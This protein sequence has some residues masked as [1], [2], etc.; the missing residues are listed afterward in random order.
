M[1]TQSSMQDLIVECNQHGD[2]LD[3]LYDYLPYPWIVYIKTVL[4]GISEFDGWA[5]RLR[6]R[7]TDGRWSLP[8][9]WV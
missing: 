2:H 4:G 8:I 1:L 9:L 6:R 3:H 7:T 5:D